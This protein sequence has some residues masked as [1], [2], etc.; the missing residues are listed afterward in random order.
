MKKCMHCKEF[1]L[2]DNMFGYCKKYNTQALIHENCK[3]IK[4]KTE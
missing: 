2:F 1:K 3:I 4:E